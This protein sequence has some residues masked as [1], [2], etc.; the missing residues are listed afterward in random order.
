MKNTSK[1]LKR[2]LS[3]VMVLAMILTILPMTA[4][5]AGTPTTLYLKPNSNWKADNARFAAYF[6]GNGEKWVSMT[7]SDGDGVYEV[8]VPAGYP[9]VIFCRM[10]PSQTA[11]NWN[12]KW[13]QTADLTVPTN[14]NNM[15]TVKEGTWDKGGGT[16][17][18]LAVTY[19]VTF[20]GTNVT[21]NGSATVAE[22]ST[23]SATLTPAEGYDLP[24]TVSVTMGGAAAQHTWDAATGVLTVAN[25][26]GNLVI[27]AEGVEQDDGMITLYFRNDWK[28]NSVNIYFWGSTTDANPSWPGIAMTKD[29]SALYGTEERD[30]YRADI[31]ADATGIIFN[32][33]NPNDKTDQQTPDITQFRDGDAFYIYWDNGNKVNK[34]DYTPAGGGSGENPDPGP[35]DE[36]VLTK[37]YY[38][39]GYINNA[40]YNG[41]DY[42]FVDGKLTVKFVNDSY[43]VVKDG[44]GDWYLCQS[45]CTGNSAVLTKGHSEKMFVDA[46]TEWT[47][48]LVENGDGTLTLS[49]AKS[50]AGGE[51]PKP[52]EPV[53]DVTIHFNM[54][55][56][57]QTNA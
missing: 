44:S 38:L 1:S 15:Y 49:Y 51:E 57:V 23:Y 46:G 18:H 34:F 25:V 28:W 39:V 20:N 8:A 27:A 43:V 53:T 29:G 13:N 10:N 35:G 22:G 42:K 40:D 41:Q 32:G 16:W 33:Y 56:V 47:F 48:T 12:N 45:H 55:T 9:N 4:S 30:V 7:D 52:T 36:P 6:F 54:F 50:E 14:G 31:P 17:S 19:S 21:S 37:D 11:N 24:E 26:T 5:A 3:M 2:L